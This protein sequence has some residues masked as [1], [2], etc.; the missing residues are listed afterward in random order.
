M[1]SPPP[2][3]IKISVINAPADELEAKLREWYSQHGRARIMGTAQSSA[4][5]EGQVLVTMTMFYAE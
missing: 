1:Q 4:S 3:S 2:G 5:H